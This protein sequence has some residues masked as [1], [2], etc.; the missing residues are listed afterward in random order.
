MLNKWRFLFVA[1]IISEIFPS[2]PGVNSPEVLWHSRGFL[3][4]QRQFLLFRWVSPVSDVAAELSTTLAGTHL[5]PFHV[6][7]LS[8][9]R[10][11]WS[12]WWFVAGESVPVTKTPLPNPPPSDTEAIPYYSPD[13]HKRHTLFCGTHIIQTRFYGSGKVK[14]VV[15]RTGLYFSEEKKMFWVVL[16]VMLYKLSKKQT[17]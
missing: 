4:T 13:A 8:L 15:A 5:Y 9:M 6:A 14:A 12:C 1:N 11:F 3:H 7:H 2:L 16:N 10:S 17:R